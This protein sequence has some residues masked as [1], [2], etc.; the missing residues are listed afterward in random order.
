MLSL[1]KALAAVAFGSTVVAS[2][3][4]PDLPSVKPGK[5]RSFG[6]LVSP[7]APPK[8]HWAMMS[9]RTGLAP[10]SGNTTVIRTAKIRK[11]AATSVIAKTPD[12]EKLK[13]ESVP[14]PTPTFLATSVPQTFLGPLL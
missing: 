13:G 14:T 6:V 9:A 8:A 2:Q 12:Y 7:V 4:W 10:V 5:E 3:P 1:R 11:R